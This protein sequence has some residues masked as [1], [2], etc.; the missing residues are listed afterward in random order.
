MLNYFG[1]GALLLAHPAAVENPFYLGG[2]D[3][4]AVSR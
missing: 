2:A 1:Q 3:V 4:G